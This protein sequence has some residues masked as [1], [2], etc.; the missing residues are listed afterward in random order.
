MRTISRVVLGA[1]LLAGLAALPSLPACAQEAAA[2]PASAAKPMYY[3]DF[4]ARTAASYGHAFVWFGRTD[5]RKV[6][7]AGLHPASDSVVPYVLGHL[8]PVP[9]ETGAS[10]GDLD[11][12]YLQASYRVLMTEAEA[13]PVFAYIKQLQ[14]SSPVWNAAVYNCVAFIQDIAR[15]MGLRVP[16]SHVMY[17]ETWV[18]QLRALNGG[19]KTVTLAAALGRRGGQA[20]PGVQ[21]APRPA[22]TAQTQPANQGQAATRTTPS[23]PRAARPAAQPTV[24]QQTTAEII[25]SRAF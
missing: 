22:A 15:Q 24:V 16:N 18:N 4:R 19:G 9:S 12:Q 21:A 23:R 5:S 13:R 3:V 17:P 14:A 11:E 8:I 20:A 2:A 10:Y 1:S 25:Q 7:V 6:E